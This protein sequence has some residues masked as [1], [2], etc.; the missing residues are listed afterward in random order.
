MSPHVS[1]KPPPSPTGFGDEQSSELAEI[2]WAL[3]VERGNP[4]QVLELLYWSE[5]PGFFELIRSLAA[6]PPETRDAL[7]AF[8]ADTNNPLTITAAADR[9]DRLTLLAGEPKQL[10][11]FRKSAR[12]ASDAC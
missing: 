3:V 10:T 8:F 11:S 1:R 12:L 5:E 4:S 2:I 7:Q 6:L 9:R